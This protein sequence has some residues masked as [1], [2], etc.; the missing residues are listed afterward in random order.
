M[1]T[2]HDHTTMVSSAELLFRIKAASL[3]LALLVRSTPVRVRSEALGFAPPPLHRQRRRPAE[4]SSSA[5]AAATIIRAELSSF[6]LR[7]RGGQGL[8]LGLPQ[9]PGRTRTSSF[10]GSA[11][12]DPTVTTTRN[13]GDAA[14]QART[15][16][17][18]NEMARDP[19]RLSKTATIL[20]L[21]DPKDDS[22]APL[23]RGPLPDG[24]R[25]LA[26]GG[27]WDGFLKNGQGSV[28]E[29]MHANAIFVSHPM[30]RE[31]LAD[32]IRRLPNLQWIHT[33][34]AGI[35]FVAS[36]DF[37]SF[38]GT[39]T[40]A[41]GQFSST[42]AEYTMLACLYFAKDVPRLRRQQSA[43]VWD[44]YI[45]RELRGSTLGVV[46]YGDIG[47]AA[48]QLA[49]SAGMKVLGWR[50]TRPSPGDVDAIASRV[51]GSDDPNHLLRLFRESDY[52]LCALPLTPDTRHLIGKAQFDAAKEGLVFINVG[53][54]PVVD[55]T[56]LI[57]ALQDGRLRGAALDVMDT[58]PLP[59]SSP[60][61][62]L[63]NV[64]LSPHNMDMTATFMRDSTA[65]YVTE[66]LPRFLRGDEPLPNL[67]DPRAGY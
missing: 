27:S 18:D 33:R 19:K 51:D 28:E 8:L 1:P 67:V 57:R 22:N 64:L 16:G 55:E 48:A 9:H 42:L 31:P 56:E 13:L 3:A 37:A 45:V 25:V 46:G 59:E 4:S 23:H 41:K 65:F 61:W 62:Q 5:A 15:G 10:A 50:R 66:L 32:L 24:A 47:R 39:V 21:S 14:Q 2:P 6:F 35:D 38:A 40:N 26:V 17:E 20:S 52:V 49:A 53:R 63:D 58:E 34:S 43:A 44:K 29:L 60:L 11:S 30:A 36:P 54:G 12:S 7:H